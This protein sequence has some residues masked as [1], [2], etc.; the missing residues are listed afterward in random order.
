MEYIKFLQTL[1]SSMKQ[2]NCLDQT[3]KAIIEFNNE[4][5]KE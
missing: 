3:N 2:W 4:S 5:G 1:P